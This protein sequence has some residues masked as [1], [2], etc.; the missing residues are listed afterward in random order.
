[1]TT[2]QALARLARVA[3]AA[4]EAR[5]REDV[6]RLQVLATE[7]ALLAAVVEAEAVLDREPAR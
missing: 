2:D 6:T 3:R 7:R 4:V 1:M 5:R